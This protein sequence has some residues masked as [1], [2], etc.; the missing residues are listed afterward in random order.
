MRRGKPAVASPVAFWPFCI[1]TAPDRHSS[2]SIGHGQVADGPG[3]HLERIGHHHQPG[4]L[5]V[6]VPDETARGKVVQPDDAAFKDSQPPGMV[7]DKPRQKL[8]AIAPVQ[9][10]ARRVGIERPPSRIGG[11]K[12][13]V[14]A[15]KLWTG[16]V[17]HRLGRQMQGAEKNGYSSNGFHGGDSPLTGTARAGLL[18]RPRQPCPGESGMAA[19]FIDAIPHSPPSVF[20]PSSLTAGGR[21]QGSICASAATP[22]AAIAASRHR[23]RYAQRPPVQGSLWISS[24]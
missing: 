15:I 14:H 21:K 2:S 11:Q 7:C 16:R 5:P 20:E 8:L 17:R 3:P 9:R 19:Y 24:R 1:L 10:P 23:S 12:R 4:Q 13:P 18:W 22:L 6:T